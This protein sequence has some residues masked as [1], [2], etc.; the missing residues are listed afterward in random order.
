MESATSLYDQGTKCIHEGKFADADTLFARAIDAFVDANPSEPGTPQIVPPKFLISRASNLLQLD[1]TPDALL[2]AQQAVAICRILESAAQSPE[3]KAALT[4]GRGQALL[5]QG[6]AECRLGEAEAAVASLRAAKATGASFGPH[7]QLLSQWLTEA[8]RD[9]ASLRRLADL[10]VTAGPALAPAS[11]LSATAAV[12]PSTSSAAP[13]DLVAAATAPAPVAAPATKPAAPAPAAIA[14]PAVSYRWY[15]AGAAVVIAFYAKKVDPASVSASLRDRGRRFT[16]EFTLPDGSRYAANI[17]L[18]YHT[19]PWSAALTPTTVSPAEA[20]EPEAAE[21]AAPHEVNE[22]KVIFKFLKRPAH[23]GESV[24][25]EWPRLEAKP[26]E[27]VTALAGT[28]G[29]AV[30]TTAAAVATAAAA[31]A[32]AAGGGVSSGA[33]LP[34]A[35]SG[36]LSKHDWSAV[37]AEAAEDAARELEK[38]GAEAFLRDIYARGNEQMKRAMMK[39]YQTSGGTVLTTNWAEAEK[40]DYSKDIRPPEG[41]T[42]KKW[43]E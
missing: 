11:A 32:P 8:E 35:Y 37:D 28:T 15:D 27:D 6:I 29:K 1:R 19:A 4:V 42:Y 25:L 9:A 14:A 26:G 38:G 39:S 30:A 23:A 17:P 3:A 22:Y 31:P 13:A 36:K 18:A 20:L 41:A 40:E 12:T 16:A 24:P 34:S 2:T 43:T 10:S 5:R 7:D 21:P 33:G